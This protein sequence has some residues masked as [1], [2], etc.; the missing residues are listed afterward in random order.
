MKYRPF[1]S[2]GFEVSA[3]GLGCMRLPTV[4]FIP[5]KVHVKKSIDLIRSAVEQGVNYI[6]TAWPYH[7]GGSAG[8]THLG[9]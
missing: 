5:Q 8:Q 4:P 9:L 6:D 1:G 3:L 2:T 7:V